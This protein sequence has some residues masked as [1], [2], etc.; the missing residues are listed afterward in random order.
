M[1]SKEAAEYLRISVGALRVAVCKGDI[2]PYRWR[3]RLYFK[4]YE[5][6]RM[7]EAGRIMAGPRY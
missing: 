6:D 1:N 5:L 2:R 3:R 7:I 4:R